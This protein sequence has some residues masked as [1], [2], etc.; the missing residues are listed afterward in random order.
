MDEFQILSDAI[1]SVWVVI[2]IGFAIGFGVCKLTLPKNNSVT[3]V[4][5]LCN[6]PK[7]KTI[8]K[9][10]PQSFTKTFINDSGK[11]VDVTCVHMGQKQICRINKVRCKYLN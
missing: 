3:T 7:L 10:Q 11:V 2:T 4:K 6:E 9:A 8:H 1:N 5:E